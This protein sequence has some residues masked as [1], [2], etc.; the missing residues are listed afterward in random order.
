MPLDLSKTP[1]FRWYQSHLHP[2]EDIDWITEDDLLFLDE[3][4]RII[5][6]NIRMLIN[7]MPHLNMLLWG[8]KGSGKSSL[9]KLFLGKYFSDGLRIVEFGSAHLSDVHLLYQI[10][11]KENHLKFILYFDDVSFDKD[12]DSYRQFKSIMEGGIENTPSNCMYA[13]SSNK[14]HI[15]RDSAKDTM[16]LYSRDE[17]NEQISL[18]S[19]FGLV[20]GFYPITK[21]IYLAVA[22]HYMK[23]YGITTSNEWRRDAEN[24]A[25]EKGGR[26]C[27]IA[28]Q[29]AIF[30]LIKQNIL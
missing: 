11:R 30:Q 22:E 2:I 6:A 8:E 10:I 19:R 7:N 12:D 17:M 4:K 5:D 18:Y 24:F 25:M 27:R 20:I 28:K 29:F 9:M 1:A 21:E 3:Q 26:S 14:R 15:I 16:D 13:L 23:K